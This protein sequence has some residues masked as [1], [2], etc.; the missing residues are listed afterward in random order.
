MS[1]IKKA[2]ERL[3]L[4]QIDVAK[5][6]EITQGSV[7]QWENGLSLPRAE[8]LPKLAALLNCTVDELLSGSGKT[9]ASNGKGA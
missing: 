6:L 2:R 7:S 3:G 4:S 9:E 8:L 5:S 1:A